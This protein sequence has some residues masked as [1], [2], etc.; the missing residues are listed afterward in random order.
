VREEGREWCKV[1]IAV[2][3]R[4][5]MAAVVVVVVGGARAGD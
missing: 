5:K 4:G 2:G 1:V 3:G